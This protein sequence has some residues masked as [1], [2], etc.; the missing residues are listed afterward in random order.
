MGFVREVKENNRMSEKPEIKSREVTLIISV[1]EV[2][3]DII[4]RQEIK[5]I[6]PDIM[7]TLEVLDI[8]VRALTKQYEPKSLKEFVK[9]VR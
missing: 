4:E 7:Y 5:V 2:G 6:V 3:L 8:F 9:D 1:S